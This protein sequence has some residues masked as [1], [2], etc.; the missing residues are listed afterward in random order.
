M[1][2][3]IEQLIQGHIERQVLPEFE[4]GQPLPDSKPIRPLKAKKPKPSRKSKA[5]GV[6]VKK[7]PTDIYS[8][9]LMLSLGFVFLSC[10]FLTLE[11]GA[12]GFGF[13]NLTPW[14]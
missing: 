14:K 11:L 13:G 10:V 8:V 6:P 9:M 4:P 2:N 7:R 5:P 3:D 1:L 12:Y